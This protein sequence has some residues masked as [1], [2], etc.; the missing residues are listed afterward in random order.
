M[1]CK[2]VRIIFIMKHSLVFLFGILIVFFTACTKDNDQ[3]GLGLQNPTGNYQKSDTIAI[4]V[5]NFFDDTLITSGRNTVFLGAYHSNELGLM[6]STVYANLRPQTIDFEVGA[7]TLY[8]SLTLNFDITNLY[9]E[10]AAT[11]EVYSLKS[12]I[13]TNQVYLDTDTLEWDDKLGEITVPNSKTGVV[14]LKLSDVY[15]SN[16]HSKRSSLFS[17]VTE[18]TNFLPGIVIVPKNTNNLNNTGVMFHL[19]LSSIS[20]ELHYHNATK[21]YT[22]RAATPAANASFFNVKRNNDNSELAMVLNDPSLAQNK[23]YLQGL[24]GPNIKISFP[25]LKQWITQNG[26]TINKANLY[27]IKTP[28]ANSKFTSVANLSF[29]NLNT[30]SSTG[31]QS[32]LIDGEYFFDITGFLKNFLNEDGPSHFQIGVLNPQTR[33]EQSVVL[34]PGHP[35]S[36]FRLELIYS[37]LPR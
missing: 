13:N 32:I 19:S 2:S 4:E 6:Q 37:K 12:A 8:D 18:F 14:K 24:N 25:Y 20:I 33:I 16:I 26:F 7:E 31:F 5:S 17:S 10:G 35:E 1:R 9:G 3:V 11:F 36:T 15:G 30:T 29:Y 22:A 27:L 23:L 28:S 34:G 21:N